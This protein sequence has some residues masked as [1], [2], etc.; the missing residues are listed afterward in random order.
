MS[1]K[2]AALAA[3]LVCLNA[4][5]APCAFAQ[6]PQQPQAGAPAVVADEAARSADKMKRKVEDLGTGPR[7]QVE[8]R[9]RDGRKLRGHISEIADAHFT[10]VERKS[11][12][13]T[14][15]A[16]AEVKSLKNRYVPQWMK[17]MGVASAIVMVP[18]AI[19]TV[20]TLAQ[21]GQ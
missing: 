19:A 12:A 17:Y 2:F 6:Q 20:V 3:L 15:V 14:S 21:G 9:L 18:L 8:V 4:L 10:V 1:K 5:I 13:T 7:A 16:Y 11:K